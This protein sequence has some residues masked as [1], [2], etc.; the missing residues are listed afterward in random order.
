MLAVL[1]PAF[2]TYVPLPA[3]HVHEPAPSA[4]IRPASAAQMAVAPESSSSSSSSSASAKVVKLVA[5]GASRS[6][7]ALGAEIKSLLATAPPPVAA[8]D[9]SKVA[10]TW[11]V[12][13]APHIDTLSKLALATFDIQ[14]HITADG[15]IGSYVRYHSPFVGA[16]WLCTDG[17]I[18]NEV[19]SSPQDPPSVRIVWDRVWWVPKDD[20]RRGP[21]TD[22]EANDV[23]L[24]D[25]VQAIGKAGFIESLSVFPVRY[26]DESLG[27]FNFQAFTVSTVRDTED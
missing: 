26:V 22:P 6:D 23:V 8:V 25:V 24:R 1:A 3:P 27:I 15:G 17:T 10:G 2:S 12:V 5:N 18:E 21:P 19:D 13:H 7:A 11:R 20:Y 14:Y 4:F 16:G 9:W